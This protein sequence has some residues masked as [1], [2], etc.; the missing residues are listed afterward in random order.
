M[1][2]EGSSSGSGGELSASSSGDEAAVPTGA[3]EGASTSSGSEG[4]GSEGEPDRAA[5]PAPP[6]PMPTCPDCGKPFV[7]EGGVLKCSCGMQRQA[8][9]VRPPVRTTVARAGKP[10]SGKKRGGKTPTKPPSKSQKFQMD[11]SGRLSSQAPNFVLKDA[12]QLYS[13]AVKAAERPQGCSDIGLALAALEHALRKQKLEP[14]RPELCAAALSKVNLTQLENCSEVLK[15][16]SPDR[17]PDQTL[18]AAHFAKMLCDDLLEPQK[19]RER[20]NWARAAEAVAHQAEELGAGRDASPLC[21][22]AAICML[23]FERHTP[24]EKITTEKVAVSAGQPH[25]QV[26][27]CFLND[28]ML[29]QD[30]LLKAAEKAIVPCAP[31]CLHAPAPQERSTRSPVNTPVKTPTRKR[32]PA[33]AGRRCSRRRPR[34]TRAGSGPA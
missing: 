15:K 31:P 22:A 28:L 1:E 14:P 20:G 6:S 23:V 26:M 24:K 27:D 34:R 29:H 16:V 11:V 8:S 4:S 7:K 13:R 25:A 5:D 10:P 33:S 19:M 17:F 12:N 3:E 2:A 30:E 9:T 18:S 32:K 21:L